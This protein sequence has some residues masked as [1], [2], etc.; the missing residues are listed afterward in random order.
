MTVSEKKDKS[1]LCTQ[2]AVNWNASTTGVNSQTSRQE[3]FLQKLRRN[4]PAYLYRIYSHQDQVHCTPVKIL[5]PY[6]VTSN[7][8]V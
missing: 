4:L 8:F 2:N 1:K 6:I 7:A 5:K 3:D